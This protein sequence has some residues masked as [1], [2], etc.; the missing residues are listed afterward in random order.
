MILALFLCFAFANQRPIPPR[1]LYDTYSCKFGEQLSSEKI[2]FAQYK[3]YRS[4]WLFIRHSNPTCQLQSI[5]FNCILSE[6]VSDRVRTASPPLSHNV[7]V[8]E[9]AVHRTKPNSVW[10]RCSPVSWSSALVLTRARFELHLGTHIVAIASLKHTQK[11]REQFCTHTRAR[12]YKC[13]LHIAVIFVKFLTSSPALHTAAQSSEHFLCAGKSCLEHHTRDNTRTQT[14]SQK[15][16]PFRSYSLQQ[17]RRRRR[18]C[19][20][21]HVRH[22]RVPFDCYT[23]PIGTGVCADARARVCVCVRCATIFCGNCI[24]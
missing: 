21:F 12:A 20:T 4:Y 9:R 8:P 1:L 7:P 6:T 18:R 22:A 17:L 11:H 5:T 14:H 23:R 10:K 16:H 19:T 13:F 24:W 15:I 2:R 3:P